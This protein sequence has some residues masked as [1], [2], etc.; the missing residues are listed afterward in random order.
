MKA[1]AHMAIPMMLAMAATTIYMF[2]DTL[3]IGQLGDTDALA[4]VP[5]CIPFTSLVLAISNFIEVGV[6]TLV[7]RSI[8][9]GD[10]DKARRASAFG[11]KW[12]FI[13]GVILTVL[14]L[15][16]MDPLLTVLGANGSVRT[17]TAAYLSFYCLGAPIIVLN[18]VCSQLVRS[19]GRSKESMVG[20]VGSALANI[21]LDPLFIFAFGFGVRGA[22]IATVVSNGLAVAYYLFYIRK[23]DVLCIFNAGGGLSA[24][25][26]AEVSKVGISATLMAALMG[27]SSLVFNNVAIIYGAAVVAAFGIAQ[28][29]VQ[30]L[31]LVAMGLYEGVVPLIGGAYGAG[32]RTRLKAILVRTALL[33]LAFSAVGCI[34]VIAGQDTIL[35]WFTQDG[36]V[37]EVGKLILT[38]QVLSMIFEAGTGLITSTFQGCGKGLAANIMAV[39]KGFITM[40]CIVCGNLLFGLDGVVRSLLASAASTFLLGVIVAGFTVRG[41]KK[42]KGSKEFAKQPCPAVPEKSG[43]AA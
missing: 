34:L 9:N 32:N 5:L 10:G 2:T 41:V 13:A 12:A 39:G 23:S 4:A 7:S 43:G 27:L 8:G 30:L 37:L 20:F 16:F 40:A 6:C 26:V 35:S 18:M 1:I 38:A 15:V 17:Q 11:I 33:I 42:P 14:S 31:D 25:E 3:F 19:I 36:M 28:N 24:Q 21:A 29:V 22:A